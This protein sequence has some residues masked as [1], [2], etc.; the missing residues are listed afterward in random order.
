MLEITHQVAENHGPAGRVWM[1]GATTIDADESAMGSDVTFNEMMS[2]VRAGDGA[3]ETALF[4]Q[5]VRRLIG[6]AARQFDASL[7]AGADSREWPTPRRPAGHNRERTISAHL[8]HASPT[9]RLAVVS[10]R[11]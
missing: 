11:A 9:N 4:Q 1:T 8:H 2:R 10:Y 5:Y 6:L 3:A 7:R